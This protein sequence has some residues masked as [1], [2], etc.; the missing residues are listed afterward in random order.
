VFAPVAYLAPGKA[1]GGEDAGTWLERVNRRSDVPGLD[2]E[3]QPNVSVFAHGAMVRTNA[4]GM[5]D[6]ER[7]KEKP[8]G[9]V[10]VAA[11]GDSFTFGFGVESEATWP[12][13][14]E[15]LLN[16]GAP[17]RRVEVLNF[18]AGGYSTQDEA[19]VLRRRALEFAPDV[20]VLGYVENDPETDPIQPLHAYYHRPRWWQHSH[21]LRLVANVANRWEIERWGDGDY[22]LY[23]HRSP[24]KWGSVTAAFRDVAQVTAAARIPVVVAL[25]PAPGEVLALVEQAAKDAGFTTVRV[26]FSSYPS[27]ACEQDDGHPNVLGHRVTAQALRDVLVAKKLLPR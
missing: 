19:V 16:E 11:L 27:G 22:V 2:Y 14:L 17:A 21:L 1:W 26:P 23:L 6:V 3:L 13:V 18:G 25:F 5:R 20:V 4:F 24:A 7:T 12:A 8:P 15:R 9:V 10:R